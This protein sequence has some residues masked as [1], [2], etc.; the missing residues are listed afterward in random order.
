M[1]KF[2]A[3]TK[4][5]CDEWAAQGTTESSKAPSGNSAVVLL[6]LRQH[7]VSQRVEQLVRKHSGR[8]GAGANYVLPVHFDKDDDRTAFLASIKRQN[9]EEA[10][11]ERTYRVTNKLPDGTYS[12][13]FEA[14]T[15]ASAKAGV[16]AALA[17]RKVGQVKV[18]VWS[19]H[20]D[21]ET[22]KPKGWMRVLSLEP[23][24]SVVE[25]DESTFGDLK[26]GDQFRMP[27]D[28]ANAVLKKI[29]PASYKVISA[30]DEFARGLTIRGVKASEPVLPE[31]VEEAIDLAGARKYIAR[32]K[33]GAKQEYARQWLL[34]C[35]GKGDKPDPDDTIPG[36]QLSVMAAQGVRL[37]LAEF[38]CEPPV[39][40]DVDEA[41]LEPLKPATVAR[42]PNAFVISF[43]EAPFLASPHHYWTGS[44][45]SAEDGEAKVYGTRK[46]ANSDLPRAKKAAKPYVDALNLSNESELPDLPTDDEDIECAVEESLAVLGGLAIAALVG[47]PVAKGVIAAVRAV[48]ALLD[49]GKKTQAEKSWDAISKQDR[50][51]VVT[52]AKKQKARTSEDLRIPAAR[53]EEFLAEARRLEVPDTAPATFSDDGDL[54]VTLD[55]AQATAMRGALEL[56]GVQ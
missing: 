35:Q 34:Y 10:L 11:E 30:D 1:F 32:I 18:E 49:A 8:M 23:N 28:P 42:G 55:A 53:V 21:A 38:G 25:G 19:D 33:N 12:S 50:Q 52:W 15:S 44:E 26:V 6:R 13:E 31:S 47:A 51:K 43:R 17:K 29:G 9:Q 20:E 5:S 56:A 22:G 3:A 27:D 39:S 7:G 48:K 46:D 37:A 45:W 14:T 4:G 24:E 2:W 16:R 41:M 54:L 40:E 36:Y